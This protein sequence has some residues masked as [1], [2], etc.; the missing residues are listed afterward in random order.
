MVHELGHFL[1][2]KAFGV[3]VRRFALGFGP[4]IFKWQRGETEYS[5]RL[6][7]LGGFVEPMGDHPDSEGGDDPRA[8]WRKPAWQKIVI[9]AAGVCMNAVLAVAFF[10]AAS[11]V[12]IG[13]P[14]PIVAD[15]REYLPA[16]K[17]GIRPNDRIVSLNGSPIDSMMDFQ[18]EVM[19]QDE[20]TPFDVVVLR[21][22]PG[23]DEVKTL[24]F[25]V[26]SVQEP[27]AVAPVLGVE[28][29]VLPR[30]SALAHRSPAEQAGLKV[31]DLI[32]SVNGTNIT[33]WQQLVLLAKD[34]LP[35]PITMK[36]LRGEKPEE[37]VIDLATIKAVNLGFDSPVGIAA[38][39]A[40]GPA[41]E[42]GLEAGDRIMRINDQPWPTMEAV[43]KAVEAAGEAG[44]VRLTVSRDGTTKEVAF[45]PEISKDSGKP[46]AGIAMDADERKP[47]QVGK[48][49]PDGPAAKAGLKPGDVIL[50]VGDIKPTALQDLTEA[51]YVADG[52]PV[53]LHLQR[54]QESLTASLTVPVEPLKKFTLTGAGAR[55]PLF[56]QLPPLYNPVAVL[57]R[58]VKRTYLWFG[59]VYINIRQLVRGHV[60]LKSMG[61]PVLIAQAS[62]GMAQHGMGT[63]LDFWG[64]LSVCIAVFNFLPI[65]PFDGGHVLFVIL[66]KIKGSPFTAKVR[67]TVWL[68]AWVGVGVLVLVI[69]Y[70]DIARIIHMYF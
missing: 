40:G 34:G 62:W 17:A 5:L 69:T 18:T 33:T 63:F 30:L 19:L 47:L 49:E 4:V 13:V 54:G 20:G 26:K 12:G 46:R 42:A 66:E 43:K 10:T 21:Q 51:L 8:L 15:V 44:E 64:I 36:V 25:T 11:I 29:P 27:G 58:S 9:F 57:E 61:G 55:E 3:W 53:E 67:N 56:E 70:Q 37:L 35:G 32:L 14:A 23:S 48:I 41:D 39:V 60:S 1:S 24:T 52:K 28:L 68:V 16:A 59:R 6:F 22:A 50:S 2:A 65:P 7:P 45:H 38:V 31:D